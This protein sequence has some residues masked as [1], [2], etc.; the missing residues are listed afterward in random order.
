MKSVP[1]KMIYGT[2]SES[3]FYVVTYDEGKHK[4][5]D[6]EYL[7]EGEY[8]PEYDEDGYI[9]GAVLFS[10]KMLRISE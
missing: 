5:W 1:I 7:H 4:T 6:I 9:M 8:V 10:N 2:V 3:G